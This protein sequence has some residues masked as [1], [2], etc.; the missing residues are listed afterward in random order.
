MRELWLT[1]EG[2][3]TLKVIGKKYGVDIVPEEIYSYDPADWHLATYARRSYVSSR[4]YQVM[5]KDMTI[6][7]RTRVMEKDG[8]L[9]FEAALKRAIKR[10][11][12]TA[13][14]SV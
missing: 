8:T 4:W 9:D 12:T 5:S 1:P 14:G 7:F 13:R 3:K 2:L 11:E 10:L 6:S